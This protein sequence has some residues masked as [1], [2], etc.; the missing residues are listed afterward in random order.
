M[1]VSPTS[2]LASP[3]SMSASPTS[4]NYRPPPVSPYPATKPSP[5]VRLVQT[6]ETPAQTATRNA[7]VPFLQITDSSGNVVAYA[8]YG[9]LVTQQQFESDATAA[10]Q[11]QLISQV[12]PVVNTPQM[13]RSGSE[14]PGKYYLNVN[15]EGIYFNSK[16]EANQFIKDYVSGNASTYSVGGYAFGSRPAADT[17]SQA[18]LVYMMQLASPGTG[19]IARG[20]SSDALLTASGY[21]YEGRNFADEPSLQAYIQSQY[22]G[23]TVTPN[24]SASGLGK[25]G[26][27]AKLLGF[28]ITQTAAKPS[29][30]GP[31]SYL[32]S[33][34]TGLFMAGASLGTL[35]GTGGKSSAVNLTAEQSERLG[36]VTASAAYLSLGEAIAASAIIAPATLIGAAIGAG[37]QE[38]STGGKASPV[39]ILESAAVGSTFS[40]VGYGA[41]LA[42]LRGAA[43][44]AGAEY[45]GSAYAAGFLRTLSGAGLKAA[46]LRGLYGATINVGLTLPFS[47]D[48]TQLSESAAIGGAFGAFGPGLFGSVRTGLGLGGVKLEEVPSA[49]V[50]EEL[51]YTAKGGETP[52]VYESEPI[53]KLGGRSLEV[54]GDV[55]VNPAPV[56][57]LESQLV[58]KGPVELA[59]ATLKPFYE[60]KGETLLTGASEMGRGFRQSAESLGLY[61]A[62]SDTPS[63]IRIYGGY[64]GVGEGYS[65]EVPKIIFGGKP[66]V[67]AV[68]E[69]ITG[70]FAP[71]LGES[72]LDVT[73]RTFGGEYSG[74]VGLP[75]ENY[76]GASEERQAVTPTA[77]ESRAGVSYPGTILRTLGVTQG[78]YVQ[79]MPEGLLGSI[80]GLRSVLARYTFAKLTLGEL[81]PV[82]PSPTSMKTI[83][84]GYNTS[85]STFSARSM[86]ISSGFLSQYSGMLSSAPS[87]S[88]L[89]VSSRTGSPSAS[90]SSMSSALSKPSVSELSISSGFS[91]VFSSLVS[92]SSS[93][94]SSPPLSPP[95]SPPSSPPLSPLYSPPYSP[96]LSLGPELRRT[97]RRKSKQ[98]YRNIIFRNLVSENLAA[99]FGDVGLELAEEDIFSVGGRKSEFEEL[100]GLGR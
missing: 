43:V 53:G 27:E 34:F 6:Q 7:D 86:L 77:F 94:P 9:K 19:N 14:L 35:V 15:G 33:F 47:R 81:E 17:Y 74:K 40:L 23:A 8:E 22:P 69:S 71:R 58:G 80:P 68:E 21:L 31:F 39:S 49:V 84:S 4:V 89:S 88:V 45:P 57:V 75:V 25:S 65:G 92:I 87:V 56:E 52:R 5:S 78:F 76:F 54:I 24:Y 62:P 61:F 36:M 37:F 55:T 79:E 29:G 44:Y 38:L 51:G 46:T 13:Y 32:T 12:K 90:R 82:G 96:P 30:E 93:P 70:E 85:R 100:V 99:T 48:I 73:R 83:P 28:T 2:I 1:S 60:A 16:E 41:S 50:K 63:V 26:Q 66:S 64:I 3:T 18:H 20:V 11:S 98:R 72:P 97:R 59:H 42:V 67:I 95:Y 91:S 10:Y